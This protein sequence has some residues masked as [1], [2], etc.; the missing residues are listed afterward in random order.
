MLSLTRSSLELIP[1]F[2]TVENRRRLYIMLPMD[3]SLHKISLCIFIMNIN[4]VYH[5]LRKQNK[6]DYK[7]ATPL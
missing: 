6:P 1:D 5:H 7:D 3:R 2:N 4:I